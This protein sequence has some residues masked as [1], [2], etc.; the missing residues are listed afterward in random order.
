MVALT[1]EDRNMDRHAAARKAVMSRVGGGMLSV[2]AVVFSIVVL[3]AGWSNWL[4]VVALVGLLVGI[5]LLV[6]GGSVYGSPDLPVW[7]QEWQRWASSV[8]NQIGEVKENFEQLKERQRAL[9]RTV[10]DVKAAGEKVGKELAETKKAL[11]VGLASTRK[12][13]EFAPSRHRA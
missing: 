8:E 1:P 5:Y 4:L 7:T 13:F 9:N 3:V 2:V 10:A 11:S 6:V 12:Q